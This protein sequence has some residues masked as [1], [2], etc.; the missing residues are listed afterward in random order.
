[1]N[2]VYSPT[3]NK[4]LVVDNEDIIQIKLW[5]TDPINDPNTTILTI[6]SL[7]DK[8]FLLVNESDSAWE[9]GVDTTEGLT[10]NNGTSNISINNNQSITLRYDKIE[11]NFIIA[12][13]SESTGGGGGGAVDSVNGQ[14]GTV[15]L[16]KSNIGLGNVD[17]T[18]DVNKPVSSAQQTAIDGKVQD[19]IVNGV[20]TIAPSQNAVFDALANKQDALGFTP[21]NVAN[22]ATNLT[23]SDNTK[24]PTTQAVATALTPKLE[25]ITGLITQGT[26]VTI[27]GNGTSGNPYNIS[28]SGG[29]GGGTSNLTLGTITPTTLPI[30]NSDGTGV[31]LPASTNLLAGLITAEDTFNTRYPYTMEARSMFP[32]NCVGSSHV[33]G[34]GSTSNIRGFVKDFCAMTGYV[35]NNKAVDGSGVLY[36]YYQTLLTDSY[37]LSVDNVCDFLVEAGYNDAIRTV[38]TPNTGSAPNNKTRTLSKI[39][40]GWMAILSNIF[41]KSALPASSGSI[42]KVGT[43]SSQASSGAWPSKAEINLSGTGYTTTTSGDKLTYSTNTGRKVVIGYVTNSNESAD[44]FGT[45]DVRIV[46]A[47]VTTTVASVNTNLQSIGT[48]D[49]PIGHYNNNYGVGAIVID[50][51]GNYSPVSI[52]IEVVNTSGTKIVIDYIGELKRPNLTSQVMALLTPKSNAIGYAQTSGGSPRPYIPT[53]SDFDDVD[54]IILSAIDNF[55]GYPISVTNVNKYNPVALL[56]ADNVHFNNYGHRDIARALFEKVRFGRENRVEHLWYLTNA[57]N[58]LVANSTY[59]IGPAIS[60]GPS[61]NQ[62]QKVHTIMPFSYSYIKAIQI[63]VAFTAGAGS[64]PFTI[65]LLLNGVAL[66]TPVIFTVSLATGAYITDNKQDV[67]IALKPTDT[68]SYKVITPNPWGGVSPT[69]IS[70]SV[71]TTQIY[72]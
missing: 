67:N 54:T 42:T 55:R 66:P 26:N 57:G 22:K 50:T 40:N 36:T 38:G 46:T 43:W 20:T 59:Y 4:V 35:E 12:G 9:V 41:L 72:L 3:Y 27:T 63:E 13:R 8:E 39:Y 6:P 56:G 69:A 64:S 48:T 28:A 32:L 18:S 65:E 44:T 52:V 31:I 16:T 15:V 62:A 7:S 2:F 45:F 61:V 33:V 25:N 10:I 70:V 53:D 5:P 71:Y 29:G 24:Y 47:G 30:T 11:K 14:T 21:E 58:N 19:T 51:L 49:Y 60:G 37:T 23:S 68:Y 34:V 1:M 17:N